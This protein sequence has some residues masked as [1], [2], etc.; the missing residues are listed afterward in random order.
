MQNHDAQQA[1]FTL[2]N[3]QLLEI[4]SNSAKQ[5]DQVGGGDKFVNSWWHQ[6]STG[7]ESLADVERIVKYFALK[8]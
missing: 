8:S 7:K 1:A 2:M 6:N 4:V 5:F 3:K